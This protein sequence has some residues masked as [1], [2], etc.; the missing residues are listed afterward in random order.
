MRV[1]TFNIFYVYQSNEIN[2]FQNIQIYIILYDIDVHYLYQKYTIYIKFGMFKE[3]TRQFNNKTLTTFQNFVK[4]KRLFH[5][6]NCERCP[7]LI[8]VKNTP[9]QTQL[10]KSEDEYV[11]MLEVLVKYVFRPLH[12]NS[13]RLVVYVSKK[14]KNNVKV[15]NLNKWINVQV[16]FVYLFLEHLLQFHM[17]FLAVI[18]DELNIVP[19]FYKYS[20]FVQMYDDYLGKFDNV[21]RVFAEWKSMEFRCF[22]TMRLESERVQKHIEAPMLYM[23]PW[24]KKKKNIYIYTYMYL[25]NPFERLKV[26]YKFLR[27][28]QNLSMEGDEDKKFLEGS[29]VKFRKVYHKIKQS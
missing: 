27:D 28:L 26:Y 14:K 5:F 17:N 7:Q 22:V 16:Q 2:I 21:L 18:N 29:L 24:F 1:T 19:D 6:V 23:L 11:N 8:Q 20:N 3:C 25:Y 12:E 10:L 9:T 15:K 4:K 13:A